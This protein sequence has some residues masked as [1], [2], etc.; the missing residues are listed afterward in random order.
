MQAQSVFQRS[1]PRLHHV[2]CARHNC[3]C[4]HTTTGHDSCKELTHN[5]GI[6]NMPGL[7]SIG[8]AE[9]DLLLLQEDMTRQE[10]GVTVECTCICI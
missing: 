10:Q 6:V 1:C 8:A 3:S 9:Y 2:A 5:V 4:A 7:S